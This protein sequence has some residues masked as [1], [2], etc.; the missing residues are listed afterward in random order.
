MRAELT[1]FGF[2]IGGPKSEV[3]V[4]TLDD[5]NAKVAELAVTEGYDEDDYTVTQVFAKAWRG[6]FDTVPNPAAGYDWD[7]TYKEQS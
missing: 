4:A 1:P 5:T 3:W 7:D 2:V 6:S